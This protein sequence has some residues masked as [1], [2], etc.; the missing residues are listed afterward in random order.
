MIASSFVAVSS[1][2]LSASALTP[3]NLVPT[4][5]QGALSGM[6]Y[7]N[8]GGQGSYPQVVDLVP[9]EWPS[10]AVSQPCQTQEV[11]VE[12]KNGTLSFVSGPLDNL[13]FWIGNLA[14]FNDEIGFSFRGP[15][16]IS[17]IA[18][19][20]PAN[21]SAATWKLTSAWSPGQDPQNLVFMTNKGG[22]TSG[23]W[24]GM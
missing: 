22:S 12:G 1:L 17:N 20:Q 23:T 7:T 11:T 9:G 16:D 5:V 3:S 13:H 2:V 24:S 6:K 15:L 8:V 4:S 14:P 10:C 19:Y 21:D 18:I